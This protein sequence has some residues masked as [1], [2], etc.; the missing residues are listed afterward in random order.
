MCISL[1][2][3]LVGKFEMK[4]VDLVEKYIICLVGINLFCLM[5]FLNKN[6]AL[7]EIRG[8]SIRLINVSENFTSTLYEFCRN[9]RNKS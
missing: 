2:I 9:I 3:L 6:L 4:F 1:N 8:Y 7:S 5:S